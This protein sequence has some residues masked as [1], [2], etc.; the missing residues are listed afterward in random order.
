M[1]VLLAFFIKYSDYLFIAFGALISDIFIG[2]LARASCHN[3]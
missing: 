2:K 3:L 1:F